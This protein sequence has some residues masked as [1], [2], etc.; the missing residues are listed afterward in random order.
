MSS[1]P[2]NDVLVYIVTPA[3]IFIAL[4]IFA[5]MSDNEAIDKNTGCPLSKTEASNIILIDASDQPVEEE[6]KNIQGIIKTAITSHE[7]TSYELVSV[8]VM[9]NKSSA[10]LTES[11][12]HCAPKQ[13][14]AITG[15]QTDSYKQA[16]LNFIEKTMVESMK[17]ISA[18]KLP[19][20]NS[21]IMESLEEIIKNPRYTKGKSHV[22]IISD[23]AQNS[24]N[25]SFLKENRASWNQFTASESYKTFSNHFPKGLSIHMCPIR[26]STFEGQAQMVKYL[27]FWIRYFSYKGIPT[28]NLDNICF[29][30]N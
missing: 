23:F 10:K 14:S 26:T 15:S 18:S 13:L 12:S 29:R 16:Q 4:I 25:W 2:K 17:T 21:P 27:D 11:L 19:S 5:A 28:H 7:L 30:E 8:L 24:S 6:L 9:N 1:P 20:D 3:A 22:T